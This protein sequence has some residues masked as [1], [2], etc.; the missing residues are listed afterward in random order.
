MGVLLDNWQQMFSSELDWHF[1]ELKAYKK[2][3]HLETMKLEYSQAALLI[4]L[5][6]K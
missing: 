5:F 2:E 3:N 4:N 6:L 1:G